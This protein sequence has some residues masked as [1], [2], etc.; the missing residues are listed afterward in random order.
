MKRLLIL[1]LLLA[2]CASSLVNRRLE[3]Y[4]T[5]LDPILH[6]AT[7]EQIAAKYGPPHREIVIGKARWWSWHFS[8]GQTGDII[9][10]G[11]VGVNQSR[12]QYDNLDIRFDSLG[13]FQEWKAWV[14]R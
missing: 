7:M 6:K 12:E 3:E 5:Q 1:T 11:G 8:Y 14:Q 10:D 2:G 13:V 4:H 9:A